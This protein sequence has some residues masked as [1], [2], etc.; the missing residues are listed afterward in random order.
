MGISVGRVAMLGTAG[1]AAD[2]IGDMPFRACTE[3]DCA[4]YE[5]SMNGFTCNLD[6]DQCVCYDSSCGQCYAFIRC[7]EGSGFDTTKAL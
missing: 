2:V 7:V 1:A 5:S 3:A 4:N 6:S